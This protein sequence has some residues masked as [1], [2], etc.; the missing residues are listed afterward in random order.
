MVILAY[1]VNFTASLVCYNAYLVNFA[2]NVN[3]SDFPTYWQIHLLFYSHFANG[4][5]PLFLQVLRLNYLQWL[6]SL[7][8]SETKCLN[9]I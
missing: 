2:S 7:D 3:F 4:S 9:I 5:S 8:M 6:L 1:T